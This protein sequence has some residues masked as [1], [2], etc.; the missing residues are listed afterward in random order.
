MKNFSPSSPTSASA[1][2]ST[3]AAVEIQNLSVEYEG[4][5]ALWG[6][7]L[8]I[9]P[10]QRIGIIGPNGSGKSTLLKACLGLIPKMSGSIRVFSQPA[11]T[12]LHRLAYV[13]QRA[14]V[15]W[16]FP[17][18]VK[19]VVMM[20]RYRK[21]RWFERLRDEDHAEVLKALERVGMSD[22]AQRGISQL[23]GGQQQRVF[24][25]RALAAGGE[26][27]V[28][29]EPFNGIDYRSEMELKELLKEL[30]ADSV[31]VIMVHHDL[32]HLEADFDRL[33]LLKTK[34]LA[35]GPTAEVVSSPKFKE[36]YGWVG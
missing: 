24:L 1:Q 6:V 4:K 2:C 5:I 7:D 17:V 11:K 27:I 36:V 20:G 31:T 33:V 23:S 14:D 32:S 15:D 21:R 30:V 12:Q 29:D 18:T 8:E 19:D 26:I 13:P 34:V 25:A 28:L 35:A 9:P 10:A 22:Y 16:D 3:G